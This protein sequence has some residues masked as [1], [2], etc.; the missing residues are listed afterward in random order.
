M[1]APTRALGGQLVA[2]VL[3]TGAARFADREAIYCAGTGRRY[4]Y[5]ELNARTN[6]LAHAM[7][8]LGWRTGDV[9]AFLCA[10]RAEINQF[11][12]LKSIQGLPIHHSNRVPAG[13]RP[14]HFGSTDPHLV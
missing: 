4:T 6:R 2:S 14:C 10:N 13:A 9:V 3:T 7:A 11:S 5:R 8:A 1:N 12:L